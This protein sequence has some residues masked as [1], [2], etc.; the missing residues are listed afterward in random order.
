MIVHLRIFGALERYFCSPRLEV[1]LPTG[2]TFRDL[3]NLVDARW[4]QQLPSQFW[5]AETKRF[6]GSVSVMTANTDVYDDNMFLS[7]QQ[8]LLFLPVLAGG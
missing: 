5:D 3:L 8:E 4:G 7:D 2:A 1:E 6:R